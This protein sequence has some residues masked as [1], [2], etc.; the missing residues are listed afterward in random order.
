MIEK[1][2]VLIKPD[3]VQRALIGEIISRFERSGLKIVGMK[4]IQAPQDVVAKH[5]Y[6]DDEWK[7]MVGSRQ[8]KELE[9][10]GIEVTKTARELGQDIQNQ[11]LDYITM[12]PIIALAIEGHNAVNF[13]R[14][15]VGA[16]SPFDAQPGTIR[17]DF[18]LDTYTL[19]NSSERSIQNLI[20]S[21]GTTEEGKEEIKLWFKEEEL[22]SW[23]RLDEA[24]I[25]RGLKN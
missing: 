14:K 12:S 19:A 8:K 6:K 22:H 20:H 17:G 2:L 15:I 18:S 7:D 3:G 21:S 13:V 4:M 24:L 23:K 10:K 5:Y 11:L 25:Y 16:T 9:E 1:S